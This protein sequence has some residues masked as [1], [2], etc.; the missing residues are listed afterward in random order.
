VLTDGEDNSIPDEIGR[1]QMRSVLADLHQMDIGSNSV[2]ITSGPEF[3]VGSLLTFPALLAGIEEVDALIYPIHLDP[4]DTLQPLPANFEN[5]NAMVK[6]H[7]ELT[8]KTTQIAKGQLQELADASGG[9]VYNAHRLEDLNGI[10]E[11]VAA[12]LGT[13]YSVAY[14]PTNQVFSKNLRHIRVQV[15][16]PDAV[17]RT[18]MVTM[19]N[20]RR[21]NLIDDLR[22]DISFG[23]RMLRKDAGFTSIAVLTLALGIGANTAVFSVVNAVLLRPLSYR[24]CDELVLI[25]TTEKQ[26]ASWSIDPPT[27]YF[28]KNINSVFADIGAFGNSTWP[29]NMTGSGDPE[30]LQGFKV[31]ANLF[32]VLGCNART[33]T[34]VCDRRR[35]TG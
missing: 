8:A 5:S 34:S 12:E 1:Q 21:V 24:N 23:L 3:R 32:S 14:T 17:A 30:R 22:Q 11:R 19:R 16:R 28:L 26:N 35:S 2:S 15:D 13:I 10:Y 18:R 7:R 20:E 31:S 4:V 27:Y 6:A 33:R 29:A 25:G 9:R